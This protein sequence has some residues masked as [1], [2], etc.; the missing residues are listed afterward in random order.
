MTETLLLDVAP[1]M[2]V[3]R[4][5][6]IG[7]AE[8]VALVASLMALGAIGT[9]AMLPALPAIGEALH[10][11]TANARQFVI[12]AFVI[13]FGVAQLVHGPLA[14][15]FG[16]RRV[17]MVSLACYAVANIA[18]AAAGSFAL[19]LVAR[20][21]G[22]AAIAATRVAT[23]AMVRDCYVGRAMARVMSIAFIVFMI[24]PVL[25]PTFGQAVLLFANWRG[26][27]WAI[28]ALAVGVFCWFGKRMPETLAPYDRLPI[29]TTRIYHGWRTALTDRLSIGYTLATT[30]LM[31][32]LYGYLNS[33][34]QIVADTFHRPT[35]L[36]LIFAT[37]A[38]TMAVANLL[39]A[40]IVM[41]VGTR[42]ISHSAVCLLA[43]S[44]LVH[45]G[46]AWSG[47]ETLVTF[48]ALQAITMA[49]FGLSTSNF[50]SMAMERMGAIAGTASS[51]QGFLSVTIGAVVGALIGQAFD[52]S[53]VPLVAGF[54]VAGVLSLSIVAITERGRLFR[55]T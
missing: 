26:I 52:G 17:L 27:F 44:A 20:A 21:L 25:A 33:I 12:T 6:P 3:Q 38:A 16:R 41:R 15:R 1:A 7:F 2:P 53:A 23:V 42:R 47:H 31:G 32:A 9:D 37:T 49:C 5:A 4:G 46:F 18:C 30:A 14:D 13:G 50:S 35:L 22:G 10:V 51:V 54:L 29:S 28:G 48:A 34:Q 8:F 45:L 40:R 55:P 43:L 24:V 36:V 39:N 11:Q 19:L